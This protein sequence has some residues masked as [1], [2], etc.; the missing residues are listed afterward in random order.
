ML[1][2]PAEAPQQQKRDARKK[3]AEDRKARAAAAAAKLSPVAEDPILRVSF[4]EDKESARRKRH[5]T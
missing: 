5:L 2:V 4:F 1:T 3:V